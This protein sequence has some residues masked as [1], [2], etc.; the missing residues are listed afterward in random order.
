M[1]VPRI[2]TGA[3]VCWIRYNSAI[4]ERRVCVSLNPINTNAT[5]VISAVFEDELV[6][7]EISWLPASCPLSG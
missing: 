6:G 3:E 4:L 5:A 1:E 2:A 7:K